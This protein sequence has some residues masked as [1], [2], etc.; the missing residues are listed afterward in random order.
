MPPP[1][2]ATDAPVAFFGEPLQ[3]RV[4]IAHRV[5]VKSYLTAC[6][7]A[8]GSLRRLYSRLGQAWRHKG[9]G[10]PTATDH[11]ALDVTHLH[12]PLLGEIWL[13]GRL[14]AIG[15]ADFDGALFH[16]F[17]QILGA[18]VFHHSLTG[19]KTIKASIGTSVGV[20]RAI[21]VQNVD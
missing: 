9:V 20:E 12:K 18:Q 17:Q 7:G 10:G 14:R 4:A 8:P 1:Q 15:M 2:L 6:R 19:D 5:R 21:F 3:V 13:D 16:G 11:A